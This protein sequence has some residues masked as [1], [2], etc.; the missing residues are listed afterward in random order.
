MEQSLVEQKLNRRLLEFINS[1]LVDSAADSAAELD[2]D[3]V[4]ASQYLD[5]IIDEASE[6]SRIISSDQKFIQEIRDLTEEEQRDRILKYEFTAEQ[7]DLFAIRRKTALD[8]LNKQKKEK[9]AEKQHQLEFRKK[10]SKN[11]KELLDEHSLSQRQ[12][13]MN[14]N[15]DFDINISPSQFS[16]MFSP[17]NS[18]IQEPGLHLLDAI[19]KY[20]N[21]TIDRIVNGATTTKEAPQ[22]HE[23]SSLTY[24]GFIRLLNHLEQKKVIIFERHE[25]KPLT[26]TGDPGDVE[27]SIHIHP[28]SD[29]KGGDDG[30]ITHYL[31]MY[32][33]LKQHFPDTPE[34]NRM[35]NEMNAMMLKNINDH[36][37]F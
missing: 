3:V 2:S 31:S 27:V 36:P 5:T 18:V 14:L 11:L 32:T 20:F 13:V 29:G 23:F 28:D 15:K 21:V 12:L 35:I 24:N 30:T 19:A 17:N 4:D 25:D 37:L 22:T 9:R 33:S 16:K 8:N 26:M 1:T 7:N 10:L 34:G 6:K